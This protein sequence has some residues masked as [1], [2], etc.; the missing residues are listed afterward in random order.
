MSSRHL[1][2]DEEQH[3]RR[4][5]QLVRPDVVLWFPQLSVSSRH[6]EYDEKQHIR[7]GPQ[8]VRPDVVMTSRVS[9]YSVQPDDVVRATRSTGR[10]SSEGR[11][12]NVASMSSAAAEPVDERAAKLGVERAVE[13]EV[14]REVGQLKRVE[15]HARQH[16]RFLVDGRRLAERRQVDEEVEELAGVDEHDQHHNDGH[17]RR[18]E[19][20][21]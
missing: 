9:D 7:R 21:T 5:P 19:S 1:E 12:P 17:Q 11:A 13:E 14:E 8:L 4:G 6:P 2:Y 18:V 20:V 15:D 10:V 3:I 16:H